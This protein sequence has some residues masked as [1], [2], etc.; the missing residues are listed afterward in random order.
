MKSAAPIAGK[1][2]HVHAGKAFTQHGGHA[3]VSH[4]FW[5]T[6]SKE[7]STMRVPDVEAGSGKRTQVTRDVNR[8]HAIEYLHAE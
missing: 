2:A 6:H 8:H 5:G 7:E 1:T 3:W 4:T